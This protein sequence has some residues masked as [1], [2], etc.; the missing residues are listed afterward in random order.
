MGDS[1]MLK[2]QEEDPLLAQTSFTVI[3]IIIYTNH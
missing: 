3:L 1:K 2:L